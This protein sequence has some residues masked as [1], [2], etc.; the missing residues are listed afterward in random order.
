MADVFVSY[1]RADREK[2]AALA[3]ALKRESLT[4]WWD[5]HLATGEDWLRKLVKEVDSAKCLIGV[6]TRNC[7][8]EDGFFRESESSG[9]NFIRIE[10]ERAG[11][12]KVIGALLDRNAMPILYSDRQCAQLSDWD[13]SDARFPE[14]R[15]LVDAIAARTGAA[16]SGD[17]TVVANFETTGS[18]VARF[19]VTKLQSSLGSQRGSDWTIGE[20]CFFLLTHAASTTQ[21]AAS[22]EVDMVRSIISGSRSLNLL[23]PAQLANMNSTVHTRAMR[24]G[25]LAEACR[26]LPADM[27]LSLFAQCVDII[28][29][30][31]ELRPPGADFLNEIAFHLQLDQHDAQRM[32][33]MLLIKNRF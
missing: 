32:F 14:F 18:A 30:D 24:P 10:H 5:T 25:M 22:V 21:L 3:K 23:S 26:T 4:V 9:H 20:A 17:K 15:K 29:A 2:A 27:R 8:D 33:E 31:G 1:K 13:L 16:A 28:M 12:G 6:W 11:P 19:D 7:V